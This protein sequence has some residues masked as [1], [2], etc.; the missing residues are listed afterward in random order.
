MKY[1]NSFV[2]NSSSSSFVIVGISDDVIMKQ[3][4]EQDGK[5][6]E[7]EY[8][9]VNC[10]YGIDE[11]CSINYYGSWGE[12]YYMGVDISKKMEEQILPELKKEFQEKVKEEYG[13]DIPLDKIKLH[14][15]EVGDG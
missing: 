6:S 7:G 1:R 12:P 2:S 14:Y 10:D 9:D 11:S 5:F 3:I 8:H 13:L 15:G 4:A